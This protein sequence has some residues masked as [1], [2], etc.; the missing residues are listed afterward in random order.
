MRAAEHLGRAQRQS[1]AEARH[2]DLSRFAIEH[3]GGRVFDGNLELDRSGRHFELDASGRDALLRAEVQIGIRAAG[4]QRHASPA[5]RAR[6]PGTAGVGFQTKLI[7]VL[8]SAPG[9]MPIQLRIRLRR[10]CAVTASVPSASVTAGG[11]PGF[12]GASARSAS[13]ALSAR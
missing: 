1:Q 2:D 8:P 6:T 9:D 11:G 5:S 13:A 4:E 12:F 3:F 10:C 7:F